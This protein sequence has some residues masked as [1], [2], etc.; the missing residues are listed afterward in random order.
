M[1]PAI[2][3]P[4]LPTLPTLPTGPSTARH[5]TGPATPCRVRCCR[6]RCAR[7]CLTS[8]TSKGW[9]GG[10]KKR[11]E[12]ASGMHHYVTEGQHQILAWRFDGLGGLQ[13][14]GV[15][16]ASSY[17]CRLLVQWASSVVRRL[18]FALSRIS[19]SSSSSRLH[20]LR[21]SSFVCFSLLRGETIT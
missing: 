2:P 12:Q 19:R 14:P 20:R 7:V 17:P 8:A 9:W 18:S 3:P 13:R 16:R 11:D 15:E 10:G 21:P 1:L 4:R 6:R 5:S